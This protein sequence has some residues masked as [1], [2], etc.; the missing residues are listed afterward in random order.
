MSKGQAF[1]LDVSASFDVAGLGESRGGLRPVELDLGSAADLESRFGSDGVSRISDRPG[2]KIDSHPER[3]YL[4]RHPDYGL[5]W[6][7]AAGD[8]I[9]CAPP[10]GA[11]DWHWQRMLTG[12]LLPFAALL[13]GLEVF[14]AS[15]VVIDGR[16]VAMVA[17]SGTGKTSVAAELILRGAEFLTDDVVALE[18]GPDGILAHPGAGLANLRR[19]AVDLVGRAGALGAVEGEDEE[20]LRLAIRPHPEPVALGALCILMRV[21]DAGEL[22]V[23]RPEPVDPRL[24]LASTFN[25]VITSPERQTRLLD[26]CARTARGVVLQ[27][28][29]P[30]GATPAATAAAVEE[31]VREAW[32][33]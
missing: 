32:A 23:A 24:L 3:G 4:F 7:S 30:P 17:A 5:H 27:A 15:A 10:D 8:R 18:A 6:I 2:F 33:A 19:S 26:V 31:A 13:A 12:Q 14:H 20:A 21:E 29:V 11:E 16:A 22:I 28:D 25:F 9:A 1:G